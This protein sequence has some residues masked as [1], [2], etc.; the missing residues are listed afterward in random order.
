MITL[1]LLLAWFVI[2]AVILGV[3]ITYTVLVFDNIRHSILI[4]LA[5]VPECIFLGAMIFYAV[6]YLALLDLIK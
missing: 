2:G 6:K 1:T 5:L 3:I 4:T